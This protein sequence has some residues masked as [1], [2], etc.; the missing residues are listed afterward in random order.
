MKK[1]LNNQHPNYPEHW[2]K[3]PSLQTCDLTKLPPPYEDYWGSSTEVAWIKQN[4]KK[5]EKSNI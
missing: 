4:Q 5:D 3:L 2:G 1:N